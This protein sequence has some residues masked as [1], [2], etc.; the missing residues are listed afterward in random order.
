MSEET[1]TETP[2][3]DQ[4][5]EEIV[6]DYKIKCTQLGELQFNQKLAE[7]KMNA[8]YNEIIALDQKYIELTQEARKQQE[9][10]KEAS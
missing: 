8:L 1:K 9:Q 3:R 5:I 2:T 10:E 6:A 4:K 7:E